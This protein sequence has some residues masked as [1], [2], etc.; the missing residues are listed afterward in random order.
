MQ[1]LVTPAP[2]RPALPAES[3]RGP[4]GVDVTRRSERRGLR[5]RVVGRRDPQRNKVGKALEDRPHRIACPLGDL[6]RR[7]HDGVV[8]KQREESLDDELLCA[9]AAQATT[10]DPAWFA[11]GR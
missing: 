3:A 6:H 10:V 2:N 5:Q 1:R 9:L 7:R 8:T 11:D 4:I